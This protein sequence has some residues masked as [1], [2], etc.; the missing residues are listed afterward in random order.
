MY[1]AFRENW[2]ALGGKILELIDYD[3][4]SNEYSAPVKQLLNVDSSEFRLQRLQQVLKQ[5]TEKTRPAGAG[6]WT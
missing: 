2:S 4:Q 5:E 3:T 1:V 6:T